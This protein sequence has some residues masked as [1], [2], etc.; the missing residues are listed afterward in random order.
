MSSHLRP[1]QT[2]R[3]GDETS[4]LLRPQTIRKG[5]YRLRDLC[6]YNQ[7]DTI[8]SVGIPVWRGNVLLIL[9]DRYK[10]LPMKRGEG[11]SS[12]CPKKRRVSP[13]LHPEDLHFEYF[14]NPRGIPIWE[15]SKIRD[16]RVEFDQI[17]VRGR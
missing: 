11:R 14:Q 9:R 13:L 17:R 2:I 6:V 3:E 5:V 12:Y 7:P 1:P 16:S 15:S 10:V 4:H 8:L